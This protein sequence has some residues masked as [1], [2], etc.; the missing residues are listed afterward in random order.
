MKCIIEVPAD[1]ISASRMFNMSRVAVGFDLMDKYISS[2]DDLRRSL[3]NNDCYQKHVEWSWEKEMW[4]AGTGRGGGGEGSE[5]IEE[6]MERGEKGEKLV[7]KR[8]AAGSRT[9]PKG[10]MARGKGSRES[11]STGA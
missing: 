2:A 10:K 8:Q 6:E 11:T 5:E 4:E 1:E 3:S 7:R 9:Y